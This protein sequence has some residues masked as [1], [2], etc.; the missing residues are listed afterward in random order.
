VN[1]KCIALGALGEIGGHDSASC[2]PISPEGS[3]ILHPHVAQ[4][5][6]V[7]PFRL[8]A[9]DVFLTEVFSF[10]DDVGHEGQLKVEGE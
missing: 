1:W 10:D 5:R 4:K 8:V 9:D 7:A 3:R 2:P 6:I